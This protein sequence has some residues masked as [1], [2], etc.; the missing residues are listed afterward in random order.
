MQLTIVFEIAQA[1]L[2]LFAVWATWR[3]WRVSCAVV[4]RNRR[5]NINGVR[6]KIGELVK[7]SEGHRLMAQASLL[8]MSGSWLC[9]EPVFTPPMVSLR[10]FVSVAVVVLWHQT[11]WESVEREELRDLLAKGGVR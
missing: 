10:A 2:S 3:A 1:V 9:M 5:N 7:G 4:E 11:R 6:Q 8:G